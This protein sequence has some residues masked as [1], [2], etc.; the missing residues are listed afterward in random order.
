MRGTWRRHRAAIVALVAALG[1]GTTGGPASGSDQGTAPVYEQAVQSTVVKSDFNG[2]GKADI[3][4]ME[5]FGPAENPGPGVLWLYPGNGAGGFLSMKQ[6]GIGWS[7]MTALVTPGDW[8]GDGTADLLARDT[9]GT[10]WLY[11]GRGHSDFGTRVLVGVGW[12]SMTTIVGSGDF[13]GDDRPDVIARDTGGRLWLYPGN[14]SGGWLPRLLIGIGWGGMTA[15]VAPGDFTGDGHADLI[16]REAGLLYLFRG[17]GDAG[18]TLPRSQI[19]HGWDGMTALTGPGDFSGDTFVDL[20]A[21]T[22]TGDLFMYRGNGA[23]GWRYL[24]VRIGIRWN[25]IKLFAS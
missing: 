3:L 15:I 24:A 18:F 17:N 11:P 4:A 10:L 25:S 23:G 6:I 16:T 20:I 22:S 1:L 5:V 7:V 19:G 21:R 13:N 2:D 14:G 12:N 8:N 9:R